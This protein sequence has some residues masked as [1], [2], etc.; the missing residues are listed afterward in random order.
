[1]QTLTEINPAP[2][3]DRR[4]TFRAAADEYYK[5]LREIDANSKK[6]LNALK[7]AGIIQDAPPAANGPHRS[8]FTSDDRGNALDVGWLNSRSQK[9]GRDMEAE[10]WEKAKV[11]LDGMD[12]NATGNVADSNKKG[13]DDSKEDTE[14]GNST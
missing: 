13:P 4:Q 14:M 1:M 6:Q 12:R 8:R 3:T 11:F 5:K 2:G 9:V 7:E 10:L